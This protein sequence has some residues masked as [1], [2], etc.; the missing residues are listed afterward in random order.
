MHQP[1]QQTLDYSNEILREKTIS[2]L[3]NNIQRGKTKFVTE[4]YKNLKYSDKI[5][6]SSLKIFKLVKK[7][8]FHHHMF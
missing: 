6:I 7:Y 5:N 4:Y 3:N 1:L 2:F 8:V